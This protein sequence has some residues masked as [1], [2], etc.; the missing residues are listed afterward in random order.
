MFGPAPRT[1]FCCCKCE[2]NM[3][4]DRLVVERIDSSIVGGAIISR[5]ISDW[6][7]PCWANEV[8]ARKHEQQRQVQIRKHANMRRL[9]RFFKW[10]TSL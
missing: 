10:V 4:T 7:K 2:S 3:D 9:V 8:L 5:A 6:C 1:N